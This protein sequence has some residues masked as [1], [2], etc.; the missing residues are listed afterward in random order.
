MVGKFKLTFEHFKQHCIYFFI[1]TYIKN[2]R[3]TLF[4]LLYQTPLISF[5]QKAN[6]SISYSPLSLFACSKEEHTNPNTAIL[7]TTTPP[8]YLLLLLFCTTN[9]KRL[10]IFFISHNFFLTLSQLT[11]SLSLCLS[12]SN[13][14]YVS[15]CWHFK[16]VKFRVIDENPEI[17]REE[18]VKICGEFFIFLAH[19]H[20]WVFTFFLCLVAEKV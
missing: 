9:T 14:Y 6:Y 8:K 10:N 17:L 5:M 13:P 3:I 12:L 4:N 7:E 11:L 1:H 18:R 15:L 19:L 20:F 2:I 16:G